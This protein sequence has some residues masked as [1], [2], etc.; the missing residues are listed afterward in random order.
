MRALD[1]RTIE[2]LARVICDLDGNESRAGWQLERLLRHAGWVDPPGYDGSYRIQWLTEALLERD[3]PEDIAR[4]LRRVSDPVEYDDGAAVAEWFRAELNR[5]LE[6]EQMT[7]AMVSGRP[8]LSVSGA[9][10]GAVPQFSMPDDFGARLAVLFPDPAL[11]ALIVDRAEQSGAAQA[12]GAHLLALFGIGSLLEGLLMATLEHRD[13]DAP[14]LD[15]RGRT[16]QL[17]RAGLDVLVQN[18]HARGHIALDAKAFVDPVRSF[19]NYIHPR[20]QAAEAFAPDDDT[21]CMAWGTVH[22][23]LSDLE[24][25]AHPV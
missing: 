2:R 1:P 9:G 17:D 8:V 5:V 4:L 24:Q 6:P 21:V 15:G 23:V 25:S 10:L 20:R 11:S 13:P 22:V 14:L 12:G 7:I 16:V 3:D 19:R 18:A